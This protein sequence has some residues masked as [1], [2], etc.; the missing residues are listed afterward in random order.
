MSESP[1]TFASQYLAPLRMFAG[2]SVNA[3]GWYSVT[4]QDPYIRLTTVTAKLGAATVLDAI[5]VRKG[6]T[7]YWY[8]SVS[9]NLYGNSESSGALLYGNDVPIT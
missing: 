6:T 9:G 4:L 7:G 8:D 2:G 1:A 3:T 5:P